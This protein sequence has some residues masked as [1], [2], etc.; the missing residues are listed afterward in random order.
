MRAVPLSKLSGMPGYNFADLELST[1]KLTTRVS[2]EEALKAP[3]D[4]CT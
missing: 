2:R 1:S 4:R 3:S